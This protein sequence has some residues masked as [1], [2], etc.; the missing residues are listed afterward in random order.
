MASAGGGRVNGLEQVV[1]VL[2]F[3]AE[4]V[5]Q[6]L[7]RSPDQLLIEARGDSMEPTIR[8]RDLLLVDV[9][10]QELSN[11]AIHVLRVG[12]VLLVKRVVRRLDG[13]L[14]V[15]S[16]KPPLPARDPNPRRPLY[17]QRLR[18]R[19]YWLPPGQAFGVRGADRRSRT[20]AGTPAAT[21]GGRGH[22]DSGDAPARA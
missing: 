1:Q 22:R 17:R 16:D 20:G 14:V 9:A 12:E 19:P 10:D 4:W 6:A 11:P 8:D 5:R 3:D 21:R 18:G 2:A 13:S 7:R 15:T